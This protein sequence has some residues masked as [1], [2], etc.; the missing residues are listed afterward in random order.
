LT[1]CAGVT[2]VDTACQPPAVG[3]TFEGTTEPAAVAVLRNDLP[4]LV[5]AYFGRGAVLADGL[6]AVGEAA[7]GVGEFP[8]GGACVVDAASALGQSAVLI[9]AASEAA[10]QVITVASVD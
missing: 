5:D 1:A 2:A 6:N 10:A 4:T 8:G 3:I 9:S 7:T